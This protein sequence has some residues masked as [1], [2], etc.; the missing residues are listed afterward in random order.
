V[1][2]PEN[3][4]R[5]QRLRGAVLRGDEFAW[6]VWYEESFASLLR[7][8]T[9]RCGGRRDHAE[10]I[11]QETWLTAIRRIR[12]F[13]P[14][15]GAFADW[16]RGISGNLLKDHLRRT[17]KVRDR[18][19]ALPDDFTPVGNDLKRQ[20]A[21]RSERI[22]EALLTLAP[23]YEAALRAKYLEGL[24]VNAKSDSTALGVSLHCE[25]IG[26]RRHKD[27]ERPGGR[28]SKGEVHE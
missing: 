14:Q 24:S 21:E 17:K 18:S 2:T 13:D 10:E 12:D 19:Q 3:V 20:Q 5:E 25:A 9:W 7:Y 1:N 11:V 28:G 4:G 8:V 6:R 15:K 23:R 16:L 27:R 26:S 22:A